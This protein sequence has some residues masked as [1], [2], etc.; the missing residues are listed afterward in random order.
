MLKKPGRISKVTY[1]PTGVCSQKMVFTIR[2]GI[3][4]K[5]EVIGGC[6][7]NSQGMGRLVVG[8]PAAEVAKRLKGVRCGTKPTSCPD[9]LA[10]AMEQ[11]LA[12]ANQT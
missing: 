9:Q 3:V 12:K 11:W 2:D 1:T 4:V 7:G 8:M 6:A 5:A 10:R